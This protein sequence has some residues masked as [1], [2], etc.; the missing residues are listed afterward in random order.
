MRLPGILILLVIASSVVEARG[1]PTP[2]NSRDN[3]R[4]LAVAR[5][6]E[7]L[8]RTQKV[9]GSWG[10]TRSGVVGITSLS[11]LAFLAQGHQVDR[12]LYG[13]ELR[14]GVR[15]L[16]KQSLPP[17]PRSKDRRQ[18]GVRGYPT[19][20]IYA[21]GD[22]DSRMHGHAYA[23]QVLILAFGTVPARDRLHGELK[24]K[25][26]DAVWVIQYAQQLT[27]GWGY[28]PNPA[29][30]HEG[31]VTVTAVQALRLAVGAGFVVDKEVHRM[32]LKY[33]HDSQKKSGSFKYALH[34]NRSSAALTAA[35][36]CALNGFG[37]YYT[38]AVRAG[39]EYL[40]ESYRR[41]PERI[42][43][44]FY[45]NYYAAQAFYRAG[46]DDWNLWLRN[47]IP[48]VLR[49]QLKRG[50]TPGAWN[51]H[52]LTTSPKTHGR[53]YATAMSCLALSVQDGY[54]PLFQR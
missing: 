23:T 6:L 45:A 42:Q 44:T 19:G 36:L 29:T 35:A 53:A 25:I 14:K 50:T 34:E 16:L 24:Q 13:D 7:Y 39:L 49:L 4:K 21:H 30:F 43:W 15:F 46:G 18:S 3:D 12:G 2:L 9:D 27:G 10:Q 32:G 51:D 1:G 52:G 40:R 54:L 20:Y 33:L 5:G 22:A 17:S 26:K 47:G 38:E 31:S 28:L 41:Q 37:E 8:A 48:Y 11:L